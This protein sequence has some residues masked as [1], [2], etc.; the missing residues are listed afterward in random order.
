MTN[1]INIYCDESCHLEH[2][3]QSIMVLG[4]IWLPD[5]RKKSLSIGLR[6]LK[7][8][9]GLGWHQEIKWQKVS[10]GKLDFYIDLVDFFFRIKDLH[11][12]G[13]IVQQKDRLKHDAFGNQDHDTWYYKMYFCMLKQ[14]FNPDFNYNTYIDIKDSRGGS[15]IRKLHDVICNNLYDFDRSII[16]RIQ[17]LHSRESEFVQMADIFAGALSYL[18]RDLKG[19]EAKKAVIERIREHSQHSLCS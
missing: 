6:Q 8:K 11:F 14:I 2:D 16:K 12:R 1:M 4:G 15:K 5:N 7:E 13:L 10:M 18:H 9:H 17:L 3:N 19:N